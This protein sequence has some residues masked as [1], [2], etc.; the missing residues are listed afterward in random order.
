MAVGKLEYKKCT[1]CSREF[2]AT[3]EYFYFNKS[4][5]KLHSWCKYC[6]DEYSKKRM[7]KW[8][9]KQKNRHVPAKLI[10]TSIKQK[11]IDVLKEKYLKGTY[12]EIRQGDKKLYGRV[13]KHFK[14]FMT[15][16]TRHYKTSILYK[17]I[18]IGAVK[19]K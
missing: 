6:K 10:N 2:P 7:Q 3:T 13:I 12:I 18:L 16:Q 9:Q 4:R 1:K 11:N 19:I 5:N 17:D 15:V 14:H 8:R